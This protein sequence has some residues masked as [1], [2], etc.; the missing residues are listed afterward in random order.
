V[1]E[2]AIDEVIDAAILILSEEL[3]EIVREKRRRRGSV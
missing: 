2:N 1:W 3:E